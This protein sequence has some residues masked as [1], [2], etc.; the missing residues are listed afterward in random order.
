MSGHMIEV[1]ACV[2]GSICMLA[3]YYCYYCIVCMGYSGIKYEAVGLLST[4][5]GTW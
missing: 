5:V 3:G 1:W 4:I 2:V